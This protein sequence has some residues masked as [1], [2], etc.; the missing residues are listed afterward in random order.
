M[1]GYRP[2]LR[3]RLA[4]VIFAASATVTFVGAATL[5]AYQLA[6]LRGEAWAQAAQEVRELRPD[7][8]ALLATGDVEAAADLVRRLDAGHTLESLVVRDRAGRALLVYRHGGTPAVEEPPVP[9]G[10]G[11]ATWRT[12]A[13]RRGE[14]TLGRVSVTVP[15]AHYERHMEGYRRLAVPMLAGL[16]ALSLLLAVALQRRISAPLLALAAEL[17]EIG[18]RRDFA[19]RVR[20]ALRDEVGDLYAGVNRM[21]EA[22]EAAHRELA[23][24]EAL[25][26]AVLEHVEE[27]VYRV[28]VEGGEL[29]GGEVEFVSPRGAE[30]LGVRPEEFRRDPA[31]WLR[32]M[33]PA[34]HARVREA[35][36][37]LARG[38]R[39]VVRV[40][41]LRDAAGEWRWMEDRVVAERDRA[42]RIVALTGVA[43]DVTPQRRWAAALERLV[44]VAREL[45]EHVAEPECLQRTVATAARE[46]VRADVAAFSL[47]VDERTCRYAAIDGTDVGLRPGTCFDLEAGGLCGWVAAHGEPVRVADIAGDPRVGADRAAALGLRAALVVPVVDE[48]RVIGGISLFRREVRPFDESDERLIALLAGITAIALR[49]QGLVLGLEDHV[50]E[51]T[52]EL[53]ALN[54]ELEA[55]AYT[56]SHDLRAPL[57][58]I[59]GFSLAVLEDEGERLGPAGRE[60]LRR[61]RAAAQ[62]MAQLIDDLL[63]LAQVTRGELRSE[64]VDLSALAREVVEGLRHV[65]PGR[66][67][68]VDIRPGAVVRGDPRL[69]WTLMENLIGNAWKFT[70]GRDPARIEFGWEET[71]GERVYYVRDNGAGFDM[72]YADKLFQPFQ[73]LHTASEF[74]GTGIGLATVR[75]VVE[76]HGGRVWAEGAVGAG[77]VIRFTLGTGRATPRRESAA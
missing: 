30:L 18:R 55:F 3:A 60:H 36:E 27:I 6:S 39:S 63:A 23:S 7:L 35:T 16:L 29:L 59:D 65:H 38:E 31:L 13:V 49:M 56:V 72:A 41:R 26:R 61:V 25:Q 24:R 77:A 43:R 40:Y 15:M 48:G 11:G 54:R 64:T 32:R 44:S 9:V 8:V 52:E 73:R 68:E 75:R 69:L 33:H 71:G 1:S 58:A 28:R 45:L 4:A 42:G 19:R 70:R 10:A 5:Y 46:I 47:R 20:T 50:R 17:R 34:D 66:R 57:R 53:R 67:V 21:L 12:I 37:A 14:E 62:R 51:R 22:L 2:G 74:E 76:R